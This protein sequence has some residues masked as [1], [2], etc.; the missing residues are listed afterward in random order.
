MNFKSIFDFQDYF[1][2][3]DD[4]LE[5]FKNRIFP[6][7]VFCVHCQNE[8]VYQCEDKLYKCSSCK[9]RFSIR[10]GTIFENSRVA[11][12]K[13]FTAMYLLDTSGKGISSVQLSKQIGVTQN[14]AW[15]MMHRIRQ[16][17]I[18]NKKE[19]LAGDVE[20][21]ETYIGGKEKNKH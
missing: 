3:D 5:F 7:G 13:W 6:N 17:N 18:Q 15:S 4:C 10:T 21:D 8:N 20:I 11:L 16:T 14:T 9:K 12:K 1:K 19:L 2:T